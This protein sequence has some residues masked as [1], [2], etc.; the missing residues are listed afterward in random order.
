MD[1]ELH[2]AAGIVVKDF[3]DLALQI[4]ELKKYTGNFYSAPTSVFG[5]ILFLT[6]P[7]STSFKDYIWAQ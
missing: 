5:E 7:T 1:L 4:W 2:N 6:C 3:T